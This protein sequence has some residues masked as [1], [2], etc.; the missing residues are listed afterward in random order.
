MQTPI[1]RPKDRANGLTK[2]DLGINKRQILDSK[3]GAEVNYRTLQ[4]RH[5]SVILL[6]KIV[7]QYKGKP[8]RSEWM[9][10]TM[11]AKKKKNPPQRK[12]ITYITPTNQSEFLSTYVQKSMGLKTERSCP[13]NLMNH[14]HTY[15]YIYIYSYIDACME[16]PSS[17]AIS[18]QTKQQ[19][20][21][22]DLLR[23]FDLIILQ[24]RQGS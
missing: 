8:T 1:I 15:I 24:A 19:T 9:N 13:Q 7:F 3:L 12:D 17:Y 2:A 21:S 22:L 16:Q 14:I 11:R 18:D 10:M 5:C 23:K 6:E 4:D 20:F